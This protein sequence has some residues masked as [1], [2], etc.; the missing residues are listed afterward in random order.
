MAP[1]PRQKHAGSS[2]SRSPIAADWRD[3]AS[4]GEQIV[5]ATSLAAQRDHITAMTSR[6]V[7]GEVEVWFDEKVFRL[8]NLEAENVFPEQPAFAGMQRAL[9]TGHVQTKKRRAKG[10]KSGP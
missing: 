1:K 8:P 4:L 10:S 5:S 9:K 3:I 6:L 2:T 7:P